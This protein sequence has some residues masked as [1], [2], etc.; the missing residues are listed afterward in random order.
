MVNT[1]TLIGLLKPTIA[2][3]FNLKRMLRLLAVPVSVLT[4]VLAVAYRFPVF[5]LAETVEVRM[6][7]NAYML[8][9]IVFFF[10]F[11]PVSVM[12][13]TQEILFFGEENP[14]IGHVFLPKPD[15]LFFKC[16]LT[17]VLLFVLSVVSSVF[18]M[19]SFWA[20]VGYF[21]AL[22]DQMKL[23]LLGSL[24]LPAPFFF[25]RF[26]LKLPAVVA[27][28]PLGLWTG[29]RMTERGGIM[30]MALFAMFLFVPMMIVATAYF[31]TGK[32][33]GAELFWGTFGV[34]SAV[35]FSTVLF[36]AYCGYLYTY[37]TSK[38]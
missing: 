25:V 9:A 30:M 34:S 29:W 21:V 19:L 12:R 7:F 1:L 22:P 26:I 11:L 32:V 35:L 33:A 17:C 18:S 27:G 14:L 31:V 15:K 20:V 36:S 10:I 13:H 23:F 38:A 2:F 5:S 4:A 16:V 6:S 37:V 3:V 8:S 24:F 28:R